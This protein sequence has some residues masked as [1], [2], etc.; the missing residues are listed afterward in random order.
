MEED[1]KHGRTT[2]LKAIRRALP[3]FLLLLAC[4][5]PP[6]L[7]QAPQLRGFDSSQAQKY[8]YVTFGNYFSDGYGGYGPVLWRVLG[9]GIPGEDDVSTDGIGENDNTLKF[10]NEDVIT[11]ENADVYCLMTEY[12]IDFHRYNPERDTRD[13]PA[14]EYKDSELYRFCT[15]TSR[16]LDADG[17]PVGLLGWLFTEDER[18]VLM[19]MPGRGLVSPPSR[20]GELFRRDYGFLNEDF[21]ECLRRQATGTYYAFDQGLKYIVDSWSWYWTT[22]RR[23]VGFRWI[24]GDN[25]H[26]SVAGADR[27]GGVR[28]VCYPHMNQLECIGGTG[29]IDDPYRLITRTAY[30]ASLKADAVSAIRASASALVRQAVHSASRAQAE[31]IARAAE[32]A[33]LAAQAR[34]EEE[35][36][37]AAIREESARRMTRTRIAVREVHLDIADALSAARAMAS[38]RALLQATPSEAI[39][40]EATPGEAT[41]SEAAPAPGA[42]FRPVKP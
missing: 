18:A 15:E 37:I 9:P 3:L 39:P 12:I 11:E 29:T 6:A 17:K 13:G 41:S 14:L 31:A 4:C 8:V 36:R 23:R 42:I 2:L 25:G 10:A 40:V 7:S 21:R 30:L 5:S 20:K 33:R 26:T 1:F 19:D 32:E 24:V 34:A 28:L 38:R 27:E 16:A 22:D 35:A